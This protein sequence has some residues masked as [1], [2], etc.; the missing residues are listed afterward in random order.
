MKCLSAIRGFIVSRIASSGASMERS[1]RD[2]VNLYNP[3][4]PLE[5]AW[6][7]PAPWYF[8]PRIAELERASV[9]SSTWQV[10]GRADRGGEQRAIF[11]RGIGGRTSRCGPRR[12]QPVAR[13]LQCLPPSRSRSGHGSRR[14][15]PN[16]FVVRT[17]AGPTESTVRL[18]AWSNLTASATS[19]AQKTV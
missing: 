13:L 9:F 7:I 1:V 11:H 17:T 8:D 19:T 10:V 12:R 2:I 5:E 3:N 15:A 14:A 6:T 4:D 16:S 18:R